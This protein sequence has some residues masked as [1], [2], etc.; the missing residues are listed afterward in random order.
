MVF[1]QS[2]RD[3][4]YV[5]G[6]GY[7]SKV[8]ERGLFDTKVHFVPILSCPHTTSVCLNLLLGEWYT[9]VSNLSSTIS[10]IAECTHVIVSTQGRNADHEV[11]VES[12]PDGL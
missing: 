4:L 8:V 7:V 12:V 1:G 5:R 6:G 9:T 2:D 11:M 10:G 3:G